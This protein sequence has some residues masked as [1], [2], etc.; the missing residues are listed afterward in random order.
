MKILILLLIISLNLHA[1]WFEMVLPQSYPIFNDIKFVNGYVGVIVGDSGTILR[2][3][4]SGLNWNHISINT[5]KNLKSISITQNYIYVCGDSGILICSSNMGE[6]WDIIPFQFQTNLSDIFFID[7][8]NG[9]VVGENSIFKTTNKGM[10]WI[11]Q[12]I[13][14][15]FFQAVYFLNK[16]TGFVTSLRIISSGIFHSAIYKTTN[17]GSDWFVQ[18]SVP[19]EELYN[20]Y[21]IDSVGY[22]VGEHEK[23]FRTTNYG[24]TWYE[25]RPTTPPRPESFFSIFFVDE[26]TGWITGDVEKIY[27][28]SN[29]GISWEIQLSRLDLNKQVFLYSIVFKDSNIGFAVGAQRTS[30]TFYRGT[31]FRTTNGG[32]TSF[33]EKQNTKRSFQ[34]DLYQNY[35]NP[36]NSSTNISFS[37]KE[38]GFTKLKVYDILG[39][40]IKTLIEE[41]LEGNRNYT[42]TFDANDLGSGIYFLNLHQNGKIK[43]IKMVLMK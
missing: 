39:H 19:G 32:I 26:L 31:I 34:Y 35:P 5:S 9:Y 20:I 12:T 1:Q 37:L 18:V 10:S 43:T 27:K 11:R 8:I 7:T 3:T 13:D 29:G 2:T 17:G 16:D 22:I 25:P 4:N 38:S 23:V 33:D 36:F 24:Y 41:N 40:E 14:N 42:I 15:N 30:S 28:T 6:S 21:F